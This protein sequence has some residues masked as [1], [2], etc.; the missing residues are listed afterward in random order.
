MLLLPGFCFL[1]FNLNNKKITKAFK[2]Y[3]ESSANNDFV[4]ELETW[5]FI[6]IKFEYLL[7][8]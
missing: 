6:Q 8:Y 5:H 3:I 7:F 2:K 1:L 4:L